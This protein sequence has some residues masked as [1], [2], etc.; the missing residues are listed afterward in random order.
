[1]VNDF[2]SLIIIIFYQFHTH[3]QHNLC[4]ATLDQLE[5]K[6]T[7]TDNL[8]ILLIEDNPGDALLIREYLIDAENMQFDLEWVKKLKDGIEMVSTNEFDVLILDL[9]LSGSDEKESLEKIKKYTKSTPI[10][11]LTEFDD[12]KF[13]LQTVKD[14]VQDYLIK[15]CVDSNTL[16]RTIRH[17]IERHRLINELEQ[18]TKE[19]ENMSTHDML[20]GLYN[21]RGFFNISEQQMNIAK[22]MKKSVSIIFADLDDFKE[23]NDTHGH[24]EGDKAL[25]EISKIFLKT[26]R[27]SD[28]VGR[29]GGDE[30]AV[31]TMDKTESTLKPMINR[32]QQNIDEHNFNC[33][34]D[35]KLSISIGAAFSNYDDDLT[36]DDLINDAD[37]IMYNEKKSKHK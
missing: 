11:I 19:L 36:I 37:K 13:A 35:Y 17:S 24:I 5:N 20:T 33:E 15:D 30:F 10:I 6:M 26:F 29:I 7:D 18:K 8:D 25:N 31:L 23:I 9:S 12:E 2:S 14:G 16:S 3:R 28:I 22:R 4:Y 32:L 27:G 1:M 34:H 21:R